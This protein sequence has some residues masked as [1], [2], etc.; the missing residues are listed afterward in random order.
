MTTPCFTQPEG[1]NIV[2]GHR[3]TPTMQHMPMHHLDQG[4]MYAGLTRRHRTA[5][6]RHAVLHLK[7]GRSLALRRQQSQT[8]CHGFG[9]L[10][11]IDASEG[12]NQRIQ[13]T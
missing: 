4:R 1:I 3:L 6:A 13:H 10:S 5:V 12:V 9:G 2:S 8:S 11:E 7:V